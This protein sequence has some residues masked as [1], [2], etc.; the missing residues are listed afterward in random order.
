MTDS[1]CVC[2]CI[3]VAEYLSKI[4]KLFMW[5]NYVCNSTYIKYVSIVCNTFHRVH[6]YYTLTLS[7]I[8]DSD[9]NNPI[10]CY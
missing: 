4:M 5:L 6:R 10:S 3:Q 7:G 9:V 2:V 8:M 1:L